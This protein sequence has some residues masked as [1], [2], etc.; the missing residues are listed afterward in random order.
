MTI[1][2]G[3]SNE[4]NAKI[5]AQAK[6][7]HFEADLAVFQTVQDFVKW[8]QDGILSRFKPEGFES[9]DPAFKD[10]D[11]AF[12]ALYVSP[13]SYASNTKDLAAADAPKS[14][15]DFL[16][17]AFKGKLVSAYPHDDDATLYAFYTITQKYGWDYVT[18]YM[19][20][21]PQFI[22]GH[23]GVARAIAAGTAL[24]TFD[25]TVSTVGGLKRAGQP[26]DLAAHGE[27]AARRLHRADQGH[28]GARSFGEQQ[29]MVGCLGDGQRLA[30]PV[31]DL[32]CSEAM[33][34]LGEEALGRIQH[35]AP[36]R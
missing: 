19:A 36:R 9:I 33:R 29:G 18:R 26:I 11:G 34:R 8:K 31:G 10:P 2:G 28:L 16:K 15:L 13:I 25:A 23:L 12:V 14:A 24:A 5:E 6:A 27:A 20:Q 35:A 17:P 21:Q 30:A 32:L 7:R 3:Y 4:L 1:T 22:Q